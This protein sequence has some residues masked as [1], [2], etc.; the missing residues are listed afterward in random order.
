MSSALKLRLIVDA[1]HADGR[2]VVAQ[3]AEKAFGIRIKAGV[4]PPHLDALNLKRWSTQVEP[5]IGGGKER[6]A[7]AACR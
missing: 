2:E 4:D 5:P 1:V 6:G 7:V 3:T